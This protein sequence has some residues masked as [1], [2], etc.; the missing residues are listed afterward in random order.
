[1]IK[2]LRSLSSDESSLVLKGLLDGNPELL[3]KA[4][5]CA[6]IAAAAVDADRIGSEVFSSLDSLDYGDLNGRA[7]RTRYGY[8]EPDEAAWELFEEKL[9]PF[10]D[11]MVKNRDRALPAVAKEYCIGII[12]GLLMFEKGSTSD[13]KGWLQDAPGEYIDTVVEEWAKGHPGS[14]DIAEV[15]RVVNGR[16]P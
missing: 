10:I 7:G 11:E 9:S 1:M 16:S 3:K 12:K 2:F 4:Y 6:I 13:L 5:D 8:T 15:M 14:E